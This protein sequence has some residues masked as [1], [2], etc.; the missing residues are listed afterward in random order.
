MM[1]KS[2]VSTC[3]EHWLE[4]FRSEFFN[5]L[6]VVLKFDTSQLLVGTFKEE[7]ESLRMAID[8]GILTP[9]EARTKLGYEHHEDGDDLMI[10]KNYQQAG[11]NGSD[12]DQGT[13]AQ[14][15]TPTTK[16]ANDD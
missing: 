14:P 6:D 4:Y 15:E 7:V 5:K 3:L 11:V 2:Y 1:L 8:A 10:S 12:T 16:E 13:D 9:N